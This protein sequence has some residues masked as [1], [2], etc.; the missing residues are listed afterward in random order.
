M[1][2][3]FIVSI[4]GWLQGWEITYRPI[5]NAPVISPY[6]SLIFIILFFNKV[7]INHFKLSLYTLGKIRVFSL[8]LILSI[9][10]LE[11]AIHTNGVSQ[12]MTLPMSSTSTILTFFLICVLEVVSFESEENNLLVDALL[13]I[14]LL[15]VYLSICGHIFGEIVLTGITNNNL[16][17]LS[18]PTACSFLLY[19]SIFIRNDQV[20]FTKKLFQR[21][22]WAKKYIFIYFTGYLVLPLIFILLLKN[23]HFDTEDHFKIFISFSLIGVFFIALFIALIHFLSRTHSGIQLICTYTKRIKTPDGEWMPI[24][25]YLTSNYGINLKHVTSKEAK[26]QKALNKKPKHI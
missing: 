25:N 5:P 3:P 22:D 1:L 2:L 15:W 23:V 8:G 6:T 14:S 16:I 10:F 7:S 17:G 20:C 26:K 21:V 9:L 13:L 11:L 24:E 19:I 4:I 18:L 12:F